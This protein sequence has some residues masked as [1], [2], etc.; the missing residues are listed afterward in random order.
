MEPVGIK[1]SA[2]V[3]CHAQANSR[4]T[5]I[6]AV[7]LEDTAMAMTDDQ[8]KVTLQKRLGSVKIQKTWGGAILLFAKF[9]YTE[10]AF[11]FLYEVSV[12]QINL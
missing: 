9:G 11:F 4:A 5:K 10:S 7:L 6:I 2:L 8:S 1:G 12:S 3:M